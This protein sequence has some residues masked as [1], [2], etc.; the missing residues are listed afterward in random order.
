MNAAGIS[1]RTSMA[2]A[3]ALIAVA[4]AAP[5]A[6]ALEIKRM[7]LSNGAV[8]LV[9][10]E[11]QLPMVTLSI[12]FD[13]GSRRD[14]AGK[15]GLASLTAHCLSQ[16]TRE[17]SAADFNQKVDFM[18]SA[19]SVDA[20]RDWANASLTSLTKYEAE[21]LHLL[22]GIVTDP[23]LRDADIERKRTE[24]VAGIKAEEERPGYPA[25]V[26]FTRSLFGDAPYGHPVEGYADSVAKL[27][28]E[29]VRSFYR[30]H[31][32]LGSAVIAV[33]GDVHADEIKVLLEKQLSGIRGAVA[34]QPV[35]PPPSVA[36]GLHLNVI[37][38]NVTQA[39]VILGFGGIERSN[40]DYYRLQVMN[41]ILGGGGFSSRLVKVVR[42]REGLAYSVGSGFSAGKFAG[43]FS[44]GLETKNAS[45]NQAIKL[46]LDQIR[47]IQEKPVS[48]EELDGAKK[49]LIGS[50]PLSIDRQ[51]GIAS[52]MLGVELNG[53]GLDYADKF[54]KLIQAVT[55]EDVQKVARTY[56]HPDSVL[57]VAVANQRE[58]AIADAAIAQAGGGAAGAPA[59]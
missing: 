17:L 55:K 43:A 2:A 13:A 29:D 50:F 32:K 22:A 6:N 57:I 42:S 20:G 16:G 3:A 4:A 53:L 54:P 27:T 19:V 51:S 59:H 49:Y 9:S 46:V 56:L 33:T 12:A 21:T 11:H 39:N 1:L 14:P 25:T 23:G 31:Y 18:G 58:A 48:D 45:A 28:A 15:A 30:D 26:K 34:S 52:F 47:E 10:E 36:P 37:D 44:V 24:Q 38:R 8:L 40:P 41:Y 7:T 5:K 35:P